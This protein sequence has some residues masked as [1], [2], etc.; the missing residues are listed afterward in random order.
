MYRKTVEITLSD[1]L[2][3]C[4]GGP[5]RADGMRVPMLNPASLTSKITAGAL[6]RALGTQFRVQFSPFSMLLPPLFPHAQDLP[7]LAP[8]HIRAPVFTIAVTCML[9]YN[10]H[11]AIA[12]FFF[13]RLNEAKQTGSASAKDQKRQQ[14]W[15][16]PP[17]DM[18]P[19]QFFQVYG[20]AEAI[21]TN[22]Y[23]ARAC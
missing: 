10:R 11:R 6:T 4:E 12:K 1:R 15:D 23:V 16:T 2:Y 19:D 3:W 17:A 5:N 21:N 14:A 18:T 8:M 7:L 9:R 22:K 20:H 13:K